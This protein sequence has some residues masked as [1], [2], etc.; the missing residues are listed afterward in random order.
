MIATLKLEPKLLS[1]RVMSLY[2]AFHLVQNLGRKSKGVRERGLKTLW[3]WATQKTG[4]FFF[5]F[6]IYYT[7]WKIVKYI[8]SYTDMHHL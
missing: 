1:L 5:V 6:D 7:A 8:M 3:K 2:K 4:I